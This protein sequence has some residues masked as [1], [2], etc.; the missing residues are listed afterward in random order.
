MIGALGEACDTC[1]HR[2]MNGHWLQILVGCI[3]HCAQ[4]RIGCISAAWH[5]LHTYG[6]AAVHIQLR[7]GINLPYWH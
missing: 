5:V 3:L 7:S 6:M 2:T 4:V 1:T